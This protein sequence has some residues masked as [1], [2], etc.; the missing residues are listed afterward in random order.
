[1]PSVSNYKCAVIGCGET[2]S[3]RAR[4][5]ICPKCQGVARYWQHSDRGATPKERLGNILARQLKLR[6]WQSRMIYLGGVNKEY[7]P[8]KRAIS[9]SLP[10][11]N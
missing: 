9:A 10:K 7:A 2:L 1:M 8:A 11:G 6:L 3:E 5:N 4:S